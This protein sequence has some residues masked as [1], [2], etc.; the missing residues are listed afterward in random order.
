MRARSAIA[1]LLILGASAF[2]QSI[3]E[4]SIGLAPGGNLPLGENASYF[5]YG[6]GAELTASISGILPVLS[7]R[8][9]LGYDYNTLAALGGA[10][11]LRAD[12]GAAIPFDIMPS[13]RLSPYILGGFVYGF[14]SDGSGSRGGASVKGGAELAYR[15]NDRVSFGLDASYRWDIGAWSGLGLSLYSGFSFPIAQPSSGPKAIKGLDLSSVNLAPVFPVLFKLYDGSAFGTFKLRNLEKS[16]LSDVTV[17]FYVASYM[18]N[19]TRL[20]AIPKLERKAQAEV[21]VKALFSESVLKITEATKV[22]AKITVSFVFEGQPY[23]REFTQV[24]RINNRNNLTWDD[25]RKAAA[26]VTPNDPLVLALGKSAVA[27]TSDL[28]SGQIDKWLIAAM[29]LHEALRAKGLR[30][31]TNPNTPFSNVLHNAS[32]IDSVWFPPELLSYGAGNCSDLTV[33]YCSLLESVGAHTAF[34]TIPGHIYAAVQLDLPP[35][36]IAK[37]FSKP[38]DLIVKEG[39]TWM[40]V[41]VTLIGRPFLDAWQTGAQEWREFDPKGK[42][43]FLPVEES[44]RVYEPVGQIP[45]IATA[46]KLPD[47]ATMAKA[48]KTELNAFIDQ[49]LAPRVADLRKAIASQKKDPKPLNSLGVAYA[50]F[51]RLD[52]AKAQ[53]EAA[54][55]IGDYEPAIVNLAGVWYLTRDYKKALDLYKQAKGQ[56]PKNALALI[57]VARSYFALEKYDDARAQYAELQKLDPALAGQY[58]YLGEESASTARQASA[59]APTNL[60]SW[61]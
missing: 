43:E 46:A 13:L 29:T 9:S 41:E 3:P 35:D 48:Y 2:A 27:V 55:K 10:H 22:S 24:L 50:Q 59:D 52:Q 14:L 25:T 17:D 6:A 18:D 36:Q 34:I 31:S 57:G 20:I 21:Q 39:K 7:P 45:P 8:L 32:V 61:D 44:W 53:F 47:L 40:P 51:G 37:V 33:L 16:E 26:F 4:M 11:L 19:P 28:P 49:E 60:M 1:I 54:S 12:A 38:Q 58:S 23:T 42:T 56:D 30:Y 5:S 15:L